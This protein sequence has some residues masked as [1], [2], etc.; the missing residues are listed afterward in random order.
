MPDSSQHL[1]T[2]PSGLISLLLA[3]LS[4]NPNDLSIPLDESTLQRLISGS[5]ATLIEASMNDDRVWLALKD[6][7]Q[8]P[9]LIS[10]L[11]LSEPRPGIRKDIAEIIFNLCGTSPLQKN[12]WS[13]KVS[14]DAIPTGNLATATGADM[15]ESFWE[16]ISALLPRTVEHAQLSQEFFEVALVTFHTVAMLPTTE[17]PYTEYVRDWGNILLSHNGKEV[18]NS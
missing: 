3:L 15:V 9:D 18:S 8:M 17:M 4:L 14:K 10:S 13:N 5:F 16:S 6:Y 11:L 7:N 1:F 12:Y 2:K